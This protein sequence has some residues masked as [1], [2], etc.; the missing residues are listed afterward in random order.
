VNPTLA[1]LA[2]LGGISL[3]GG[4]GERYISPTF[5]V[6]SQSTHLEESLFLDLSKK[7]EKNP[8]VGWIAGGDMDLVGGPGVVGIAYR[9]RNGGTWT[10]KSL[11]TRLGLRKG[12]MKVVV[13]VPV[14]RSEEAKVN[15]TSYVLESTYQE[16]LSNH[17]VLRQVVGVVRWRATYYGNTHQTGS[18]TQLLVGVG[19]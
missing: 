16:R 5:Q 11:L 7:L 3:S 6:V 13:K 17:F 12:P 15:P 1:S 19:W 8:N 2:L 18:Y 4:L 9:H 10:K 14:W